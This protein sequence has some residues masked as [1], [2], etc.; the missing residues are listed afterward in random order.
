MGPDEQRYL[1]EILS[2]LK[3]DVFGHD[4]I[5]ERMIR[6]EEKIKH[7]DDKLDSINTKLA[8]I[9]TDRAKI[10]QSLIASGGAILAAVSAGMIAMFKH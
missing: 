10:T 6:M 3:A 8:Q 1:S 9:Q 2:D 4:G 7:A 5:K